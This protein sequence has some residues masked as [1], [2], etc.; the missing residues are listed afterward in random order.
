MK[1]ILPILALSSL[2]TVTVFTACNK[3]EDVTL[4]SEKAF[5]GSDECK[6]CHATIFE[7]FIESGHPYKLMKVQNGMKPIIPFMADPLL[8]DGYTWNKISYTIGGYGWKMRFV[9]ENGYVITQVPGSQWNPGNNSRSI[10]NASVPNGT[11]KYTCGNCHT[12]GWKSVADGGARQDGL[13]GM[14]GEFVMGG[15]HCEACH[16]EGNVHIAAKKEGMT[17]PLGMD[18]KTDKSTDLCAKC[19]YR[20]WDKGDLKQQ[21]SGGWEMHRN[22]VEQLST[23]A[24]N[25]L[26]CVGC[27][28]PHASTTKNSLAKGEGIK[29]GKN[30][31]NCHSNTTKYS[32]SMHFSA[33]CVQ[34]HMPKTAKNGINYT[35]YKGDAP[36]HNFKINTSSTANYLTPDANSVLWA[37][38]DKKGT[39]LEFVCYQCHKDENGVGGSNSIKTRQELTN[40]AI[41]FHK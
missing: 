17:A 22:Q 9:D 34:C 19:H 11:E 3:D 30:C 1:R 12:T 18:V 16:G 4:P 39:T 23:N 38:A 6:T 25:S 24:H 8:P 29:M 37:N 33:T 40:K 32:T 41:T 15:V 31:T 14:D 2:L 26:T 13:P 21:V 36:N 5:S 27:H 10:Y 7:T 28:D 20:R 35:K